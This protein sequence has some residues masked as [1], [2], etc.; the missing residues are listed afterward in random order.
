[1]RNERVQDFFRVET[2]PGFENA[3]DFYEGLT[4]VGNMVDNAEIEDS[5]VSLRCNRNGSGIPHPKSR[6]RVP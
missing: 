5:V 2:P 4:P 3:M 1:M 6:L